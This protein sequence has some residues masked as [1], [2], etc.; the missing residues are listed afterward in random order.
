MFG[1]H[2]LSLSKEEICSVFYMPL[3]SISLLS[4]NPGGHTA[5]FLPIYFIFNVKIH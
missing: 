3:E 5:K 2:C 1:K 4:T